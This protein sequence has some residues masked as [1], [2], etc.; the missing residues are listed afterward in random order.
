MSFRTMP[1]HAQLN[2]PAESLHR[3]VK[4]AIQCYMNAQY[5][6]ILPIDFLRIR[7]AC[8]EDLEASAVELVYD[9]LLWLPKELL[10]PSD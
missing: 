10:S 9:P 5:T 1:Y 4:A 7:A 6:R 8:H 3:Q 2:E